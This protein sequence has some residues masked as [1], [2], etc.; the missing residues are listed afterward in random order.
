MVKSLI[1]QAVSKLISQKSIMQQKIYYDIVKKIIFECRSHIGKDKTIVDGNCFDITLSACL[2]KAIENCDIRLLSPNKET[3]RLLSLKLDEM[4]Q[5]KIYLGPWWNVFDILDFIPDYLIIDLSY[6]LFMSEKVYG[7]LSPS[8]DIC[9]DFL[10]AEEGFSVQHAVNSFSKAELETMFVVNS[11]LSNVNLLVRAIIR[12]RKK[13]TIKTNYDFKKSMEEEGLSSEVIFAALHALR[14]WSTDEIEKISSF[15]YFLKRSTNLK[16]YVFLIISNQKEKVNVMKF[17]HWTK[18][19]KENICIE[20]TN[21][22]PRIIFKSENTPFSSK[23][24]R[25]YKKSEKE[26]VEND[27]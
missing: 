21:Y 1:Q 10:K 23:V 27:Y 2:K 11:D 12:A 15:F 7:E 19:L 20:A 16:T 18:V 13:Q 6:D 22:N 26:V 8:S 24:F 17:L 25:I 14:M 4:L 3:S 9:L 5:Q